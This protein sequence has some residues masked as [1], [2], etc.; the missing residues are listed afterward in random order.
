MKWKLKESKTS[1][2][3]LLSGTTETDNSGSF[4]IVINEVLENFKND[5]RYPIE[6]Q[7]E[8]YTDSPLTISGCATAIPGEPADFG[9]PD[10]FRGW[11][12]ADGCGM[13]NHYCRWVGNSGSGGDPSLKTIHEESFWACETVENVNVKEP[14]PFTY[15]KCEWERRSSTSTGECPAGSEV[16]SVEEC[17]KAGLATGGK[18]RNGAVVVGAWGHTPCGCFHWGDIHFDT[19]GSGCVPHQ[20]ICKHDMPNLI[21][22]KFLCDGGT[23]DCSVAPTQVFVRHLDFDVPFVAIDDTTVAFTGKV[24]VGHTGQDNGGVGDGCPIK[25]VEVCLEDKHQTSID[26]PGVCVETDSEGFYELPAVIGTRVT[27]ELVYKN[28]TFVPFD[29][30]DGQKYEDGILIKADGDYRGNDFQDTTRTTLLVQV[31]GGLCDLLLGVSTVK[32]GIVG[33]DW[34]MDAEQ[35]CF[36]PCFLDRC[37][38][39]IRN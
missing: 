36:I 13:C 26:T 35:V 17:R 8:K 22:H 19:G 27:V 34:E 7:F 21:R 1:S 18:L 30:S 2:N 15:S 39:L 31:A 11:Y 20:V 14:S 38:L 29:P 5:V 32:I 33:C 3:V 4:S 6:L 23:M 9:F 24:V 25:G 28:H 37:I 16:Q 12:D 10:A